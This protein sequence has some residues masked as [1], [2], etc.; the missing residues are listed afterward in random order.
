MIMQMP[1]FFALFAVLNN[2]IDLRRAPF[3]GW[4]HDLSAPD[5]LFHLSQTPL[6]L[7][8]FAPV[9]LLPILMALTGF[10]SQKFTPTDPKQAPTMYMM[11]FVMLIF[12]YNLP[13]GLVLYWTV[14]NLMTAWQQW[15]A[16]RGEPAV[17]VGPAVVETGRRR[18]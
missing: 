10:L 18:K 15:M 11:N 4:I 16:L 14:M 6:P 9:R 3:Y 17:V 8:G 7:V 12:F 2:A 1:L 5:L 13:S